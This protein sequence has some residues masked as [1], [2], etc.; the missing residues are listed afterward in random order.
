MTTTIGPIQLLAIGFGP[1][2]EYQG[3][4]LTEFEQL[5][6]KGVV[7]VLDLLFV[8]RDQEAGELVAL[9]HQGDDLGG[10]VGALLGFG[11]EGDPPKTVTRAR[12]GHESV[13]LTRATL[14]RIIT[15]APPNMAIG[16]LLVEHVWARDF[17][18]AIREAGGLPLAEGFLSESALAD[19][20]ADL[21]ETVKLLD[22]LEQED[23]RATVSTGS[24]TAAE[25]Y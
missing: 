14:E 18:L 16:L 2:A 9:N 12:A 5:E 15:S 21:E 4:I 19:I 17:K 10:L 7:R 24:R 6:G 8:G 11:F 3:Q 23:N 13:G 1:E 20:A 25:P 22:E